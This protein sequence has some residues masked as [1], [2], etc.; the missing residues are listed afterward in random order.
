MRSS[1]PRLRVIQG[2]AIPR[3]V[4]CLLDI[5]QG[6][7]AIVQRQL[8]SVSPQARRVVIDTILRYVADIDES[9]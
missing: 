2:D 8:R 3:P 7:L 9:K 1:Q 4:V 6:T 5:L